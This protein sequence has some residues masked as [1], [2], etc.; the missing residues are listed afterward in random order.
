MIADERRHLKYAKA[1][2]RRYAPS[3]AARDRTI[4]R[5]RAAEDEAY[6]ANLEAFTRIAIRQDLLEVGRVEKIFWKGIASLGEAQAQA[7]ARRATRDAGA[8]GE[9]TALA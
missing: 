9:R 2:S 3:Q 4:D 5:V 1:I 6:R 8:G 7:R